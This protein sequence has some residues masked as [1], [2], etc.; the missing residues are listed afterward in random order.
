MRPLGCRRPG[1]SCAGIEPVSA[2]SGLIDQTRS[3]DEVRGALDS[4][5]RT[6]SARRTP[7][8]PFSGTRCRRQLRR[9]AG[10]HTSRW[11][12]QDREGTYWRRLARHRAGDP[13]KCPWPAPDAVEA[14]AVK[15][16]AD[17]PARGTSQ[18]RRDDAHRRLPS[19]HVDGPARAASPWHAAT[20]PVPRGSAVL[21]SVA[22]AG[23]P[24]PAEAAE[25]GLA[26][27]PRAPGSGGR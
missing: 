14:T 11:T 25:P 27:A 23:V 13:T 10:E 4:D 18:D 3:P 22:Q 17:W 1:I 12:R 2:D 19:V 20:G 8:A 7:G 15:Y 21:G 16:A 5:R 26:G 9:S 6:G 24:R